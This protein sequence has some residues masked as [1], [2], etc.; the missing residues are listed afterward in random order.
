MTL[1]NLI[2]YYTPAQKV[3][4]RCTFV[5][6][7]GIDKRPFLAWFCWLSFVHSPQSSLQEKVT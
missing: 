5:R 1:K 4:S 7:S 3:Q 2:P 6:A